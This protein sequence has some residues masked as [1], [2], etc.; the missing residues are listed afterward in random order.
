MKTHLLYALIIVFIISSCGPSQAE[1]QS[2]AVAQSEMVLV[3]EGEFVMGSDQG[4]KQ[5][6]PVHQVYL[7]AYY[8]DKY[9]VTN[10]LYTLCVDAGT[11]RGPY[12]RSKY[13]DP[14]YAQHPVVYVNWT[15]AKAFC[16]WRGAR[17]PTEAEWEK[18]ARGTDGRIY[19]WGNEF[20][21][22]VVNFCD[23]NCPGYYP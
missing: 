20:N 19:P 5:E 21:G 8:I 2:T 6:Q 1:I 12:G 4:E 22:S 18:A 9:E 13:N 16:E 7:N 11:C 17:L 15:M 14:Q 23:K 3:P 10:A